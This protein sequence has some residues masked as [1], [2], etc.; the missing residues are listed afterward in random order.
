MVRVLLESHGRA[1]G[2]TPTFQ[3]LN[4]VTDPKG[5]FKCYV[6]QMGGGGGGGSDFLGKSVT[7]V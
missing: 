2:T 5:P 7:M 4:T 6:T 3:N 1:T